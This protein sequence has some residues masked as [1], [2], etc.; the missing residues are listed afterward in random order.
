MAHWTFIW[1][2]LVKILTFASNYVRLIL[3]LMNHEYQEEV[4]Q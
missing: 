4:L 3:G 1:M 2:E